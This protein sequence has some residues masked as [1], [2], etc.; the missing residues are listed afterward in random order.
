LPGRQ[1]R[2]DREAQ[3]SNV[4]SILKTGALPAPRGDLPIHAIQMGSGYKAELFLPRPALW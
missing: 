1:D 3:G 2:L 4:P